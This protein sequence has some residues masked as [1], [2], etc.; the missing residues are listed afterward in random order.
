MFVDSY[1]TATLFNLPSTECLWMQLKL[2]SWPQGKLGNFCWPCM[3]D[4]CDDPWSLTTDNFVFV[5]YIPTNVWACTS[6]VL[7]PSHNLMIFLTSRQYCSHQNVLVHRPVFQNSYLNNIIKPLIRSSFVQ[8]RYLS[9]LSCCFNNIDARHAL[10]NRLKYVVFMRV[11]IPVSDLYQQ[12]PS[13]YSNLLN[14]SG[15]LTLQPSS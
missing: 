13:T 3:S 9:C 1:C 2:Y 15:V 4:V 10:Y 8:L 6:N 12:S 7:L 14:Y 5:S 11:V